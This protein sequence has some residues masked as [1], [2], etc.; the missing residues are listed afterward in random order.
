MTVLLSHQ[1]ERNLAEEGVSDRSM[2][3][4]ALTAHKNTAPASKSQTDTR[5]H[6]DRDVQADART[7]AHTN[8]L[9]MI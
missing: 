2:K 9:T 4:L 7:H 6:M 1:G 5:T 8:T 3:S